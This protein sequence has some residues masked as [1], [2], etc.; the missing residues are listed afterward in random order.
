MIA[1]RAG[2]A[3]P[4]PPACC[5]RVK[6]SGPTL[7]IAIETH[8]AKYRAPHET[9]REAMNRIASKL[10]DNAEHFAK[11]RS[12]LLDMRFM[13]AGRVQTS[14]G[15]TK[16]TTAYNCFVS[17]TI[18]D[19]FVQGN[20]SIMSR[21]TEA[22]ATMRQGGGI[23]YDFSTFRHGMGYAVWWCFAGEIRSRSRP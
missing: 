4:I 7:P 1:C 16:S 21:A 6:L 18:D 5:W 3:R 12:L 14:V 9:F 8:A 20:A 17:G 2:P 10:G 23:G 22:A 19:S 13:P 11:F 15:S